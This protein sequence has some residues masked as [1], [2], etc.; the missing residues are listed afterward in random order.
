METRLERIFIR[1]VQFLTQS[2][3]LQ[4][5]IRP[6]SHLQSPCPQAFSEHLKGGQPPDGPHRGAARILYLVSAS[7]LSRKW[8]RKGLFSVLMKKQTNKTEQVPQWQVQP[9]K[10]GRTGLP[11]VQRTYLL[12]GTVAPDSSPSGISWSSLRSP[13]SPLLAVRALSGG[14]AR[15]LGGEW[16]GKQTGREPKWF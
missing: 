11:P 3:T 4:A 10:D 13:S 6:A 2:P 14:V 12:S 16:G 5:S 1:K 8:L 9:W 15:R 7:N